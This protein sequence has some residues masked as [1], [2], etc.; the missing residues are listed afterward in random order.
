MNELSYLPLGKS[1]F[2]LQ[3][4]WHEVIWQYKQKRFVEDSVLF[5]EFMVLYLAF[6]FVKMVPQF[7]FNSSLKL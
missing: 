2:W 3:F 5:K 6:Y 4:E 7:S 1:F